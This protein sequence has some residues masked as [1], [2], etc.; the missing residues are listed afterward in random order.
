M[1]P[2]KEAQKKRPIGRQQ[3]GLFMSYKRLFFGRMVKK[4]LSRRGNASKNTGVLFYTFVREGI[5]REKT[6]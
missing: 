5:A 4:M 3:T 1:N 6:W 2:K